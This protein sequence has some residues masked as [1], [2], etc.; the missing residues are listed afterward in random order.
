MS[1]LAVSLLVLTLAF[2]VTRGEPMLD[3]RM[4]GQYDA[5]FAGLG[6]LSILFMVLVVAASS[7]APAAPRFRPV[8]PPAEARCPVCAATGA[9]AWVACAKCDTPHHQQC[10]RYAG[11]C[12]VFGCS[13]VAAG[14]AKPPKG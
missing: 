2:A 12:A 8:T 11:R 1:R 6:A 13:A 14:D 4:H 10:V 5:A 7:G 9:G 3:A